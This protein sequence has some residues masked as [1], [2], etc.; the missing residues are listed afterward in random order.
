M[1]RKRNV[2]TGLIC[3]IYYVNCFNHLPYSQL[4]RNQ[5]LIAKKN[6]L[7]VYTTPAEKIDIDIVENTKQLDIS[8]YEARSKLLEA[9]L[10]TYRAKQIQSDEL[11]NTLSS[12][13]SEK[14]DAIEKKNNGILMEIEKVES[15]LKLSVKNSIA[16]TIELEN[17]QEKNMESVVVIEKY[18]KRLTLLEDAFR[19]SQA[20]MQL[21][22]KE[23]L[24]ELKAL[25][26]TIDEN[27]EEHVIIEERQGSLLKSAKK[28]L[29][30]LK[31]EKEDELLR[32]DELLRDK[33]SLVTSL[34]DEIKNLI[35]ETEN[36]E[37]RML[38]AIKGEERGK[39]EEDRVVQDL[40]KKEE[41][42]KRMMIE[43]ERL[44]LEIK[45]IK[46]T[47]EKEINRLIQNENKAIQKVTFRDFLDD[48]L[49]AEKQK[50]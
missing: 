43:N 42:R 46:L 44:K 48:S 37:E 20:T 41:E 31:L 28:E 9:V 24:D 40:H 16:I 8:K 29:F 19:E 4:E 30:D 34:E 45:D 14:Y 10:Q 36:I 1:A 3:L 2:F 6:C 18:K 5:V 39:A 17:E 13:L 21:L 15:E 32:S 25:E 38:E 26:V 27:S 35:D 23:H 50:K 47:N 12:Q 11:N 33:D 49:K 22:K 7:K